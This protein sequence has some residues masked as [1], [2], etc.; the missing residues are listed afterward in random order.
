MVG[1]DRHGLGRRVF[2]QLIRGGF[3]GPVYPVHPHAR[4]IA[5]VRAFPSIAEI[6]D[7]VEL[8]ILAVPAEQ[9]PAEID[10]C[11]AARVRVVL[12]LSAGFEE[13]DAEAEQRSAALLGKVRAHGMRMVG[14]TASG[15]SIP[16]RTSASTPPS[17]PSRFS[18]GGLPS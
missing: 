2:E 14:P 17:C 15:C 7:E 11:A 13:T 3:S 4:S 10:A 16:L 18:P 8:A 1:I 9:L 12:V 5:A 6:P